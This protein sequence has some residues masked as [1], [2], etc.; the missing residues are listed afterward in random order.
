M[1]AGYISSLISNKAYEV[2]PLGAKK[3]TLTS[4]ANFKALYRVWS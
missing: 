4:N 1:P 2:D 3:R